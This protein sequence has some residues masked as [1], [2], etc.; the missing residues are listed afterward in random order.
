[1]KNQQGR[2]HRRHGFDPW[3]GKIPWR[4]EWLPTC[5]EKP[6]DRVA[7]WT[8]VFGIAESHIGRKRLSMHAWV[9]V[10]ADLGCV[11]WR[12]VEC[13]GVNWWPVKLP[14]CVCAHVC[15]HRWE[16]GVGVGSW[17]VRQCRRRHRS[18]WAE[19]RV[20]SV[21]SGAPAALGLG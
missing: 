16:S 17:E 10:D 18:L 19:E 8:T 14:V 9:F 7:C 2:S 4:R 3:V 21:S 13:V 1:M 5:L 15:A 11:T 20:A 12:W 6:V